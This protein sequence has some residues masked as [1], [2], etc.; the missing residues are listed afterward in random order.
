MA[1]LGKFWKLGAAA[2]AMATLAAC[3]TP[4]D[5]LTGAGGDTQSAS[6]EIVGSG[7]V[8]VT[9]LVPDSGAGQLER[10]ALE[11]KNAA[12]MAINDIGTDKIELV[13]KDTK[14]LSSRSRDIANEAVRDGSRL[15][16]G[17][18]K[19]ANVA[20]AAS[21]AKPASIPI[22]AFTADTGVAQ[23]GVYL[24]SFPPQLDTSRVI[25]YAASR[26]K[27]NLVAVI[28]DDAYGKAVEAQLRGSVQARGIKLLAIG[29][30]SVAGQQ[31]DV[32]QSIRAAVQSVAGQMNLADS[33][34]VPFRAD[35]A[36]AVLTAFANNGV[37][38][39]GKQILASGLLYSDRSDRTSLKGA[40]FA[41]RNRSEF[42]AFAARYTEIYGSAPSFNAGLGY[43]AVSLAIGLSDQF[44][45]Q[46]FTRERLQNRNG[47]TGVT[48]LFRF[49]AQG[50]PER[51]L[52]IYEYTGAVPTVVQ[53]APTSFTTSR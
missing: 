51:G 46:A 6:G 19:S 14:G 13:I 10:S 20:A 16:L 15:I 43:D 12:K 34:F 42:D 35:A 32:Q 52:A 28:P 41:E 2:L 38:L 3:Q 33:V 24:N 7:P 49:N 53:A 47:F 4:L 23:D 21:V 48:G 11:L 45:A 39:T 25:E 8:K 22:L 50:Q 17:P 37:S 1:G 18:V 9:L 5:G 44:G 36:D 29:K 40:W 27:K 26:G 30:Y 31:T